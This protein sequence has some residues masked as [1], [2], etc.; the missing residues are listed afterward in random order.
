LIELI[1]V[2][3]I[4]GILAAIAIP[5]YQ[6]YLAR[7]QV[8]E[9]VQ[10]VGGGKTPL[11]EFYADKGR[12]PTSADSVMGSL[13]GKYVSSVAL[14]GATGGTG[15]IQVVATMK[16]VNVSGQLT[17]HTLILSSS[18]GVNWDCTG[19]T[20]VLRFRPVACKP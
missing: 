7:A 12:W 18:D 16:S 9:A 1:I 4:L 5:A 2:V 6:D 8:T 19:G 3:A 10:L 17:G 14:A 11:S 20:I 15:E 13:Q